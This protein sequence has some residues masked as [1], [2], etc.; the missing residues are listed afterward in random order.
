V[1][2][3]DTANVIL[4]LSDAAFRS[5][6]RAAQRTLGASVSAMNRAAAV[7]GALAA[8]GGLFG[9]AVAIKQ[10][11]DF[12]YAIAKIRKT[13]GLTG[14]QLGSF[15][16]QIKKIA[17]TMAGVSSSDLLAIAEMGGRLGISKDGLIEYTK[18][19]A[20]VTI[21][22]DDIPAE[23]AASSLARIAFNFKL[24]TT[25]TLG[26]ASALNKLD[27]TSTAT[28]RDILDVSMRIS[29][30][31]ATMGLTAQEVFALSAVLKDAGVTNEV[32]GTAVSG[33]MLKMA[34]STKD[35]AEVAGLSIEDFEKLMREDALT[36][37]QL[38][39][40]KL[41]SLDAITGI[42][43]LDDLEIDGVRAADTFLKL[44]KN[45]DS[46][47]DRLAVANSEFAS[48][49]SILKEVNTMGQTFAAQWDRVTNQFMLAAGELGKSFLPALKALA[50]H[51]GAALD[52][53]RA[54][55]EGGFFEKI[56]K[57]V[58]DMVDA[59][60]GMLEKPQTFVDLLV[61]ALD[62][63]GAKL[64]E[65]M[66]KVRQLILE[67]GNWWGENETA[68]GFNKA[69]QQYATKVTQERVDKFKE[70]FETARKGGETGR[71]D[72]EVARQK[73]IAGKVRFP[74]QLMAGP[75]GAVAGAMRQAVAAAATGIGPA[76]AA[77]AV[78]AAKTGAEKWAKGLER[79]ELR[80]KSQREA[81]AK[82]EAKAKADADAKAKPTEADMM[83]KR[84]GIVLEKSVAVKLP[85]NFAKLNEEEQKKARTKAERIADLKTQQRDVKTDFQQ[86]M[87]DRALDAFQRATNVQ[88]MSPDDFARTIDEGPNR[89]IELQIEQ[90]DYLRDI[91]QALLKLDQIELEL[92]ET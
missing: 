55:A 89:A 61:A 88:M 21:A 59:F 29:G 80:A 64:E 58:L 45:F 11:T 3:V 83:A 73:E 53:F 84:M 32:A 30:A 46:V 4:R 10:A 5:G 27:D 7:G 38:V 92:R 42:R 33:I 48:G 69:A 86:R 26:L 25:A 40:D 51:L 65:I 87:Q 19:V 23:E 39:A 56:A 28:G 15:V 78:I 67:A 71:V 36:A 68:L 31:G 63:L 77:A 82:A 54:L 9:G 1:A 41:G 43:A 70:V 37:L 90:R 47:R 8:A 66:L 12:E 24:P 75:A 44:S 16:D 79:V 76:S 17:T 62:V 20:M 60:G 81:A 74:T 14:T 22:L 85:E 49:A 34:K 50:D 72:R 18:A 35:F 6:L 13:T 2:T 52:R 91:S 57:G